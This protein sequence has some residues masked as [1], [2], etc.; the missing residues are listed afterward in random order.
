MVR[1]LELIGL[2]APLVSIALL[3][4]SRRGTPRTS[5]AFGVSGCGLAMA[6]VLVGFLGARALP[7]AAAGDGGLDA[8]ADLL[9]A[10]SLIR[11][12]LL[13]GA[14]LLLTLAAL[15]RR[16][17]F[18]PTVPWLVAAAILLLLGLLVKVPVVEL[19]HLLIARDHEG[20]ALVAALVGDSVEFGALGLG[21]LALA[22]AVTTGRRGSGSD[23]QGRDSATLVTDSAR[24]AWTAYRALRR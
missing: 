5:L 10:T 8:M 9:S 16:E 4:V 23:R 11:L 18:S 22:V 1:I 20:L 7:L 15:R 19:E 12:G 2:L 24:S 3:I 21:V 17:D 13:G 14:V 6:S